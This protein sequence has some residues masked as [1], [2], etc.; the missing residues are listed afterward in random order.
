[1]MRRTVAL[2]VLV[3]AAASS[4]ALAAPRTGEFTGVTVSG[5]L[6]T[7]SVSRSDPESLD[8]WYVATV[9]DDGGVDVTAVAWGL[10]PSASGSA[11]TVVSGSECTAYLTRRPWNLNANPLDEMVVAVG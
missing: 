10:M 3:F 7:F 8:V 4:V 11:A 1:M 5:G 6:A 9:C 2:A